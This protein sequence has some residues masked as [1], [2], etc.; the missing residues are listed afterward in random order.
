MTVEKESG[1]YVEGEVKDIK[2]VSKPNKQQ[3]LVTINNEKPK[4]FNLQK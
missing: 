3:I 2:Q 1:F 4:L